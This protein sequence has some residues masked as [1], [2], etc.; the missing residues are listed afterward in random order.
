[1]TAMNEDTKKFSQTA[2]KGRAAMVAT[3]NARADKANALRS[4]AANKKAKKDNIA[5][6][7][8]D[9]GVP[10]SGTKQEL[11]KDLAQQLH[12]ETEDEEE[13]EEE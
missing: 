7:C 1:M 3:A 10:V 5:A 13:E 8:G 9:F 2:S 6:L 4:D 11:A 12:Y